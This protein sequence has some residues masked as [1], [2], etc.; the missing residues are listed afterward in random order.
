MVEIKT[1]SNAKLCKTNGL[2]KRGKG[3]N[4]IILKNK[5]E[6]SSSYVPFNPSKNGK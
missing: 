2:L 4:K 6:T 5:S 1:T 3:K